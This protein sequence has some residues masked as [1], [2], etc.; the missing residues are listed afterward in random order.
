MNVEYFDVGYPY[1]VV[2]D[3]YDDNELDLI[4]RELIFLMDGDKLDYPDDTGGAKDIDGSIKKK[5]EVFF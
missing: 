2:D 5:I 1:I 3:F 4:W